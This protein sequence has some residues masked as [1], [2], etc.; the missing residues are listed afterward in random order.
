MRLI[1]KPAFSP[2]AVFPAPVVLPN[3]ALFPTAVNDP[4]V[5]EVPASK[6][7]AVTPFVSLFVAA[8]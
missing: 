3:K 4:V 1:A 7:T 5:H 2:T 6:P 8:L